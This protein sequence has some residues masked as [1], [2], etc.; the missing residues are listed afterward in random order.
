MNPDRYDIPTENE[1]KQVVSALVA[2]ENKKKVAA[3][4][5]AAANVKAVK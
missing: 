4:K 5:E 1:I 2:D 3:P